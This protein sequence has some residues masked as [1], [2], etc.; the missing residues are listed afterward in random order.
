MRP[1]DPPE[2]QPT[3][4]S[5]G[6]LRWERSAPAVAEEVGVLRHAVAEAAAAAG[7][8]EAQRG[9]IALAVSEALGNVVR[10]AY[11]DATRPGP[12]L[13]AVSAAPGAFEVEVRDEG[14]G[15]R[16]RLDSPGAGLGLAM[17]SALA[18]ELTMSAG[19]AGRGTRI[20]MRFALA[21]SAA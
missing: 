4:V 21:P 12:M 15:M 14:C 8:T 13:L 3:G 9:D 18:S 1:G 17:I 2:R 5:R 19:E 16:P 20:H 11:A 7:A 10:H 6:P